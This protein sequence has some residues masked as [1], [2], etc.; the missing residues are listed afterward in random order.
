MKKRPWKQRNKFQGL[1]PR[2][3]LTKATNR[4]NMISVDNEFSKKYKIL[5]GKQN[6]H[7]Q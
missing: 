3:V 6:E 4:G 5:G 2:I 1:F 7:N